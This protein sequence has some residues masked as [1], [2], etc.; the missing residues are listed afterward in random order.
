MGGIR[1]EEIR[2]EHLRQVLG[3]YMYYVQNTTATFHAHALALDEMRGL[4]IFDDPK[5]RTYVIFDDDTLCGYVLLTQHKRREAYD[6]T[7]EVTIYLKR[8]IRAEASEA[9][10][11]A[12]SK[13]TPK[14][15]TYTRSSPRYAAKTWIASDCLSETDMRN[16]PTTGK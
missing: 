14:G 2:E 5:Y 15:G 1:F 3:I 11:F 12:S 6:G 4:V 8:G 13:N 9:A 10:R 7:A 16:A